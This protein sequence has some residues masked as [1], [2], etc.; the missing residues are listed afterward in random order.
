MP[1]MEYVRRTWLESDVW[2][3]HSWSVYGRS[4]RTNNDVEGWHRRLNHKANDS[5][6][7]FYLLAK[8][9]NDEAVTAVRNAELVSDMKL[10]RYQRARYATP[11]G[12]TFAL[13]KSYREGNHVQL[14]VQAICECHRRRRVIE[15]CVDLCEQVCGL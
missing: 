6:P 12:K 2:P 7:P 4:V 13:W 11:Q 10:R 5:C 14:P 9:L 3:V 8:F 15:Q 1:L